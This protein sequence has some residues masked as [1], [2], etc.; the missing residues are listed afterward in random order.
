MVATAGFMVLMTEM[1][2]LALL[3]YNRVI[4]QYNGCAGALFCAEGALVSLC[5]WC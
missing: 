4:F 2:F 5:S 3:W 1:F